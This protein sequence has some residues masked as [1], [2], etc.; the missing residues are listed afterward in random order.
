MAIAVVGAAERILNGAA[1]G[2]AVRQPGEMF[3]APGSLRAL[4]VS[5]EFQEFQID[6]T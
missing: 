6:G 2:V 1:E 5:G 4:R 3:D